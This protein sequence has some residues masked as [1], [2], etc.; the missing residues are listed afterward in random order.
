M[1]EVRDVNLKVGRTEADP[2]ERVAEPGW[3][4][5]PY[6]C[7][8]CDS[9]YFLEEA[10]YALLAPDG[11]M[12]PAERLAMLEL[13]PLCCADEAGSDLSVALT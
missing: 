5:A 1:I 11:G 3:F 10:F 12:P 7:T 8:K 13:C 4:A 9:T 6:R 2:A